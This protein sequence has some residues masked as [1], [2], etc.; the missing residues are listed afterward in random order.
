MSGDKTL[1]SRLV[2]TYQP[3]FF[4]SKGAALQEVDANPISPSRYPIALGHLVLRV[5]CPGSFLQCLKRLNA[6]CQLLTEVSY[7]WFA[8]ETYGRST[9]SFPYA[10]TIADSFPYF[11]INIAFA[12]LD[13]SGVNGKASTSRLALL[14]FAVKEL[15]K[16][17]EF[18]DTF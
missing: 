7:L 17:G 14:C 6:I 4:V 5:A 12:G 16:V 15:F 11:S 9:I 8:D 10:F 13:P 3:D 18:R 2:A 1:V